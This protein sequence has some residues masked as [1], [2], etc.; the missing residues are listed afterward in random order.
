[1]CYNNYLLT[2]DGESMKRQISFGQALATV[3]GS[4]IGAGVFFKIGTLRP[5]LAVVRPQFL[6]GS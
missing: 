3:V 5:K 6:Y 1:M 2:F 4:V